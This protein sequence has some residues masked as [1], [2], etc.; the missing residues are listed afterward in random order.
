VTRFGCDALAAR[1]KAALLGGYPGRR[2]GTGDEVAAAMAFV[3]SDS[4][5]FISGVALPVDGAYR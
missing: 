4:A 3:L 2:P 1:E 5:A